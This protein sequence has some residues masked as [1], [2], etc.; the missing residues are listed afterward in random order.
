MVAGILLV[1]HRLTATSVDSRATACHWPYRKFDGSAHCLLSGLLGNP[2]ACGA[3]LLLPLCA[4][5]SL[6]VTVGSGT[7]LP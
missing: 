6:L 2:R 7:Q 1:G 3:M 5:A 4:T